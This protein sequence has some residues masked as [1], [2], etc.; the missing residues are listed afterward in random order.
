MDALVRLQ[1]LE[2]IRELL[3]RYAITLDDHA[4][5][6]FAEL[7]TE[8]ATFT[9]NGVPFAGRDALVRFIADSLPEDYLCK[10]I[11][12]APLI[13][14]ATDAATARARTD[15]LWVTQNYQIAVIGRY[16]DSLVKRD[17]RW[18]FDR[19]DETVIPVK[20]GPVPISETASSVSGVS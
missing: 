1:E 11:C 8:E 19:R 10:H 4:W 9:V 14:L 16:E 12:T 5:E 17:G 20:D 6:D 7:F 18:L 3:T 2:A 15:V 13:E